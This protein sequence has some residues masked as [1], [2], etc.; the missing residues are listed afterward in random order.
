MTLLEDRPRLDEQPTPGAR[1]ARSSS[2]AASWRF[3][4]RLARR[5]VR[6]RPG[7]TL[8]VMLLVALPV[9]AMTV[10][11]VTARTNEASSGSDF[12]RQFG[13]ADLQAMDLGQYADPEDP[14]F[15]TDNSRLFADGPA[16]PAGTES[17]TYT[18]TWTAVTGLDADGLVARPNVHFVV[19]DATD[20]TIAPAYRIER[21]RAA[22][23]VG[24]VMLSDDVADEFGVD[25]GDT[26]TLTRPDITVTVVGIHAEAQWLNNSSMVIPG[27]DTTQLRP[28]SMTIRTLLDVPAATTNAEVE[29]LVV[30][31]RQDGFE[32]QSA[33][34]RGWE[35]EGIR[36]EQL[37]WGWVAG[38]VAFIAVG[39]VIA[40][41][42]ATS[43]R[44]QL[45]TVGQLSANGAPERLVR[46]TLG[47]Q[48]MWTGALGAGLGISLGIAA[49][50]AA[51]RFGLAD[52]FSGH[53]VD[54]VQIPPLE[55]IVVALTALAAATIAALVP[56]RSAARIPVL[57]ALAGRRPV[58]APPRWLVPVGLG[59]FGFGVFL[60]A[61]AASSSGGGN[62]PAAIAVLGVL[63]VLFG[64]VCSSPLIV[65]W[66]SDVGSRRGGVTRIAARSLGRS[67]MRS[68][69][70]LTAVATV[71]AIAIAGLTATDSVRAVDEGYQNSV[72]DDSVFELWYSYDP[73]PGA[74]Y[75][76]F[77]NVDPEF[78]PPPTV[79]PPVP[80]E[81]RDRIESILPEAAWYELSGVVFDELPQAFYDRA[82]VT[83]PVVVVPTIADEAA[84][85]LLDLD[86]TQLQRL[87]ETGVL[88][89]STYLAGDVVVNAGGEVVEFDAG[90]EVSESSSLVSKLPSQ[91]LPDILITQEF[92]RAQGFDTQISRVIVDNP[93]DFTDDERKELNAV[94]G[95][96][97]GDSFVGG[98]DVSE[99]GDSQ[100]GFY[101]SGPSFEVPWALIQLGA[102]V[103]A[104]V[105]VLLVV[106]IGLSLAATESK[107]ERDVLHVVGASPKTLRRVA[108]A[109]AWVLTTGAAAVSI[110]T[111]YA[112]VRVITW[113]NETTAPFP[114]VGAL[115]I[116]VV[117]PAVAWAAT[118]AVSA[119]AQKFRPVQVSTI[120]LD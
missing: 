117:I 87:E 55:L 118:L 30:Q 78:D 110:P 108:A 109:K 31:L 49:T 64:I 8:L 36:A 103:A 61:A 12:E 15:V 39:I 74:T 1:V 24:E 3:S 92:A 29:A 73:Y 82:G 68:A 63:G 112:V 42:F 76:E 85:S 21:G 57:S 45:A 98:G 19:V 93:T 38:V 35:E 95:F 40:A 116:A 23:A 48:G 6:R 2:P 69:G 97:G 67:R 37:A 25:V 52:L 22:A 79:I 50:L 81:L 88:N 4:A 94:G 100:W 58:N 119:I 62:F 120:T 114:I 9:F 13:N 11:A 106:A 43:A 70:V 90:P 71:S 27:F 59:L 18:E 7:R 32:S 86:D 46:R 77:G 84:L 111:G 101:V 60:I 44:R 96:N 54:S 26:L 83:S 104:L 53:A 17:L 66:V 65:S 91:F 34:N 20:P 102:L 41:A 33:D 89:V 107:D 10:A 75:D 105:M 16:F 51:H 115:G 113:V 14:L 72:N 56:A 28:E 47:L 99:S 80:A 5:E